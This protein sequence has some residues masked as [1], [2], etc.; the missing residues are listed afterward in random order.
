M[1]EIDREAERSRKNAAAVWRH[2]RRTGRDRGLD[3]RQTPIFGRGGS[4]S[5][6]IFSSAQLSN[7]ASRGDDFL[8]LVSG[9]SSAKACTSVRADNEAGRDSAADGMVSVAMPANELLRLLSKC[10][11]SGHGRVLFWIVGGL[12]PFGWIADAPYG[13]GTIVLAGASPADV[14]ASAAKQKVPVLRF[15]STEKCRRFGSTEVPVFRFN[16]SAGV[17]VEP[18][19]NTG[20]KSKT[21]SYASRRS[22]TATAASAP[23]SSRTTIDTAAARSR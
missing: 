18:N 1:Q 9:N 14:N 5:T 7:P 3:R 22:I 13:N 6:A 12:R 20:T 10:F 15:G 2:R 19:R 17:S 8:R 16:R 11:K 23:R 21:S 4:P